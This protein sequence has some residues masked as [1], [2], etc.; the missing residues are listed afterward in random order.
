MLK[1]NAFL[2]DLGLVGLSPKKI[3][4]RDEFHVDL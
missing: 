1:W 2:E 4:S 3:N